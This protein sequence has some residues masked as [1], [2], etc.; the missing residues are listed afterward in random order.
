MTELRHNVWT[1]A[2]CNFIYDEANGLP[3]DG[4]SP[5][6]RWEDVPEDWFCPECGAVKCQFDRVE[7]SVQQ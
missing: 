5:G 6:T 3:E 7:V 2:L 4:L 1:C